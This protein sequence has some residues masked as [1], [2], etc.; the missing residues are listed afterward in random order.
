MTAPG[1]IDGHVVAT[2][3]RG[4]NAEIRIKV[5]DDRRR[6]RITIQE[7]CRSEHGG[8]VAQ[9]GFVACDPAGTPDLIRGLLAA[10]KAL[11]R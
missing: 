2:V 7:F 1:W 11:E 4:E 6:P 3:R 5:S 10:L 9:R 8:W